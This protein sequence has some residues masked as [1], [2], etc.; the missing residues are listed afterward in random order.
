MSRRDRPPRRVVLYSDAPV[1]GGHE[2][3]ACY[4]IE[5]LLAAGWDCIVV[6]YQGNHTFIDALR[7]F[8]AQGLTIQAT[9]IRYRTVTSLAP[10]LRPG[11]IA[12]L[13]RLFRSLKPD[14][15]LLLQDRIETAAPALVATRLAGI[16]A[17][18]YVP[19]AH[20]A[21]VI[22][23]SATIGRLRD[24]SNRFRYRAMRGFITCYGGAAR[25]IHRW[26]PRAQVEVVM[27][28]CPP[29]TQPTRS[30]ASMRAAF[31]LTD[32]DQVV[33]LVG[34]VEFHQKR[35]DFV[36]EHLDE[37]F[38][39]LERAVLLI[40]GDGPDLE[41]LKVRVSASTLSRRVV[42]TGWRDDVVEL[43][44]SSDVLLLPSRFE[45]MPLTMLEA[46]A[47]GL[48][49]IASAVDGMSE[50]LP[51]E[52]LFA[53]DSAEQI[54]DVLARALERGG[55]RADEIRKVCGTMTRDTFSR[56]FVRAVESLMRDS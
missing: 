38:R 23:R 50:V 28:V 18:S 12:R 32:S 8:E 53:P 33:T 48:P 3:M 10:L 41:A 13:F 49:V 46:I 27:N 30:R 15:V 31:G 42:L 51:P 40:V 11:D 17:L 5:A 24:W 36:V 21:S 25:D 37:I 39:G 16:T 54:R 34:R 7:R 9:N 43:L 20:P 45:G 2:A 47:I 56:D 14:S 35:Q 52:C 1:F 55:S 26:A 29:P 19:F 44:H 4:A 22:A 6:A